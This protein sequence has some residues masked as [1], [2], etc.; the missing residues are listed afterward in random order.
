MYIDNTLV[1][2]TLVQKHKQY[3][4]QVFIRL[5]EHNLQAKL[6][7]SKFGMG[8]VGYLGHIVS[9]GHIATNPYKTAAIWPAPKSIEE[10]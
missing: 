1:V 10:F 9:N 4:H 5:Y 3:L 7:K 2:S 8:Q 6:N